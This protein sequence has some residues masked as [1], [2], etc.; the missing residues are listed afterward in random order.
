MKKCFVTTALVLV[1]SVTC[2]FSPVFGQN[3]LQGYEWLEGTWYGQTESGSVAEY[4]LIKITNDY[5]QIVSTRFGDESLSLEEQ[6]KED[7]SIEFTKSYIVDDL[8]GLCIDELIRIDKDK[9]EVFLVMGEYEDYLILN[10]ID[11]ETGWSNE[12]EWLYGVWLCEDFDRIAM[13][14][15]NY[16]IVITPTYYKIGERGNKVEY[17]IKKEKDVDG[18]IWCCLVNKEDLADNPDSWKE[19]SELYYPDNKPLL[20]TYGGDIEGDVKCEKKASF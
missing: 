15:L 1:M 20:Y 18:K 3:K 7:Y 17:V 9:H 12:L 5:Y 16:Y 6:D 13:E 10:R 4:A 19:V 2:Y 8:E 14:D 11:A